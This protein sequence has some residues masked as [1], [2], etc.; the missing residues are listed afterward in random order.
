MAFE[1]GWF[2]SLNAGSV[3]GLLMMIIA[4]VWFVLGL[5]AGYIF[6]YPPVLFVIGGI[7][8]IK[9][10]FGLRVRRL[11]HHAIHELSKSRT[12]LKDANHDFGGH[13]E[14]AVRD[15]D[16]AIEQLEGALFFAKSK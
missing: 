15:V 13:R 1:E 12:E 5:Q 9:G 3:G 14:Q 6:F 8:A 2:G 11:I 10:F 4:A 7:A 16:Y